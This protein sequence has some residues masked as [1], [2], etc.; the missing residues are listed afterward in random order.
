MLAVEV[1]V[2]AV[3]VVGEVVLVGEV[4]VGLILYTLTRFEYTCCYSWLAV[5]Q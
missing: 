1:L 5:I 3:L 2:G 4:L